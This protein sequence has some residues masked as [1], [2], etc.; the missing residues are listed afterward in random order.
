MS[1]VIKYLPEIQGEEQ[2]AVA[3]VLKEMSEEQA[4]QFA[5]VYRQ[6]RKDPTMTLMT[7]LLGFVVV[8]G[9][10]RFYL[11]QIGMGLAYLFT[12]GF[13]FIGTIVDLFNYRS[14]TDTY[15]EKEALQVASLIRGAFP[16]RGE[17]PQLGE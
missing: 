6:R 13:C 10:H 11:G 12:A 17:P 2:L 7:A 14:L 3:Q 8:S 15:N 1:K 5:H 4:E 9:V 16:D